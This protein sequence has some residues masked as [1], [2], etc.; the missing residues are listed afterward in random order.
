MR[1]HNFAARSRVAAIVAFAAFI[2]VAIM[3][4]NNFYS[5]AQ[6][7]ENGDTAKADV[8]L[9][10]TIT[11]RVFQDFNGNGT[12]DT[13]TGLNSIDVGVGGVTVTAYDA[14]G[15]SQGGVVSCTGLNNPTA[16]C[17]G[18]N[19]GAYNLTAGGVGPYRVEF[20]TIPTGFSPSARSTDS[21]A[22]GTTTNSGSTVQFVQNGATTDANLALTRAEEYCQ[23]NPTLVAPRYAQGAS[24]GTYAANSVLFDFPY[25]AGTT[26]TDT[27]EANYDA[28]TAHSLTTSV[29]ALGTVNSLAYNRTTNTI[30]ASAYYKRHAGFGPGANGTLNNADDAGAIYIVNAAT[31]AVTGTLTVPLATT[32]AHDVND[33]NNDNGNTGWDGTGKTSLGGMALADDSSKLFVMNLEN[34]SLYAWTFSSSTWANSA[35][36]DGLTMNTPGG[37]TAQ[38]A[39]GGD[40]RPF[41]VKFYRGNVYIGVVCTGQSTTSINDLFA[42]VFQ[43]NPATLA[44][45]NTPVYSLDL[46][47]TRGVANPGAAAEWQP[48]TAIVQSPFA[49]PQAWLTD[50]DFDNDNLILGLRDRS[51]DSALDLT[52]RTAGDVVRA[53]GS[54]GAWTTEANG[55]CGGTGTAPQGTGQGPGNGEFYHQDDFCTAPNN[56]QFHDEVAWGAVMQIPGRQDVVV[57]LLDPIDRVI[58]NGATFDGGFRWMNST[59][60]GTDRAYRL[61]N[62]NGGAGDPDFGK[63][64]GLGDITALC[65]AAP[66]EIGNRVWRDTN[67]NGVQD[68]GE[69]PIAG[70]T[71]RLY[72][73]SVL[74]GTAV[75]DA[76]GEYYFVSSTTPDTNTGDNVGQ[77]NGGIAFNTAYQVRF[78]NPANYASGGPLFGLVSTRVNQTTQNGDDDSSDSDAVNALNPLGSPAGTFPVIAITTGGPGSNNHTLDV[79]FVAALTAAE[80]SVSGQVLTAEGRGLTNARV[81]LTEAD[82]TTHVIV[83]GRRG[84]FTFSEIPSGQTV[85]VNVASRRFTFS[86]PNRVVQL[87]DDVVGLDF[88]AEK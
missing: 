12:F 55:R 67:N 1:V 36:M 64:N 28:P 68:P 57:T 76:N 15:V 6:Q 56:G 26:Y 54:F 16:F 87:N 82:G 40:R 84:A 52:K 27:V 25:N 23:N 47:Y 32:N 71:V 88:V 79:G 5:S 49:Y 31:S 20:T 62:G 72:L 4:T 60:G 13:A 8:A 78:D 46:D 44:I 30:Y 33:Y 66:I 48:W 2:L 45:N 14:A 53:C 38:C 3:L 50:I 59:T 74:V 21:V 34:R 51:G 37:T 77:V 85:V 29:A 22:G 42:Y 41:A 83:T 69:A 9:T 11:G 7:R 19:N 24:N 73:G 10:G 63:T 18:T 39:T 17:T 81:T 43:V 75:T 65:S 58:A 86:E 61:Y 35:N 70:V 80:V